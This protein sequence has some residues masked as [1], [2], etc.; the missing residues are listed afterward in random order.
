VKQPHEYA[1]DIVNQMR[2]PDDGDVYADRQWLTQQIV[3]AIQA[4]GYDREA[5][6]RNAI[7]REIGK[8]LGVFNANWR[9]E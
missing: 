3:A 9:E 7:C 2:D 4:Y 6:T 8:R 5:A 1:S